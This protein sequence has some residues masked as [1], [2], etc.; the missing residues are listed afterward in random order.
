MA[1]LAL[2]R[3]TETDLNNRHEEEFRGRL[4]SRISDSSLLLSPA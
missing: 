3:T 4:L 1:N 2:L